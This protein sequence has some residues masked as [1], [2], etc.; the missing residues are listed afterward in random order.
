LW[1]VTARGREVTI[2]NHGIVAAGQ[3][4]GRRVAADADIDA[5]T[6][7]TGIEVVPR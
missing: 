4:V 1:I 7:L 5:A 6:I 2:H 3:S